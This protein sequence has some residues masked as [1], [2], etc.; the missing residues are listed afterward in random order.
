MTDVQRQP[1]ARSRLLPALPDPRPD[2]PARDDRAADRTARADG[3]WC[4][5]ACG[6]ASITAPSHR[7]SSRGSHHIAYH[8]P[9]QS[10]RLTTNGSLSAIADE[11]PCVID[12]SARIHPR[13]RPDDRGPATGSWRSPFLDSTRDYWDD[14]ARSLA[15]PFEWQEAVIRSAI[16][17][18]LC[19]YEDTGA[20]VAALTTSIPESADT[21]ATGITATAG[22]ATAFV[23]RALNRLGA[24][25]TMEEYI[26]YIFNLV[27][28]ATTTSQPLYG[29]GFEASWRSGSKPSLPAIAAWARC[30]RQPR[31]AAEAARRVRQR[32]AGVDAAVLRPAPAHPGDAE[33]FERLERSA[34]A[35][36]RCIDQPDAGLWEFRGR[37]RVHTYSARCAGPA[38]DRLARIAGRSACGARG[39]LARAR[40]RIRE[41]ILREHGTTHAG[42]SPSFGGDGLDA[43]RCC[44]RTSASS[45]PTTRASLATVDAIGRDLRRATVCSATSRRT[46]SA[47]RKPASPSARSG[48]S[49]RWP[50][51]RRDEAR[52]LFERC[53]HVATRSAC[54]R[55]TSTRHGE[56]WGNF[57]QT[58]SHVG[59]IIAPCA[60]GGL[61]GRAM[62]RARRRLEPGR[63]A[64]A[65]RAPGALPSRACSAEARGGMWFGWS[66]EVVRRR[67]GPGCRST[68]RQDSPTSRSTCRRPTSTRYYNGFANRTLWPL[69]HFRVDA[70]RLH[71]ATYAAL[72]AGQRA[73]RRAAGRR[74]CADDDL[75]WVHD[76]HLIPL[77]AASCASTA[78]AAH[79]FLPARAV[80]AVECWRRCRGTRDCCSD[81]RL[82]PGRLPDRGDLERFRD[83]RAA[84]R[85]GGSVVDDTVVRHGRRPHARRRASR[86]ASTSTGSG[87]EAHATRR[88]R[89]PC[90]AWRRPARRGSSSASTGSTTPRACR[91]LPGVR[92]LPRALSGA[93]E[94]RHLPADRAAAA[95]MCASTARSA[96]SSTGRRPHQRPLRGARLDAVALC[97][98]HFSARVADGLLS[99]RQIG[100]VTPLR[101]GMNLVAKEFVAAQD[102]DDPGVLVLSRSP[103]PRANW[104]SA[105]SWIR[106]IPTPSPMPCTWRSRCHG[107]SDA[108]VTHR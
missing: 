96:A 42:I 18:K 71:R 12:A 93:T 36:S 76:Y 29:I 107:T 91:T 94:R 63:P 72:P 98:S 68:R 43:S 17:L 19:Q 40:R 99:R 69:L 66:G 64:A 52:E 97:Q 38:C 56:L 75:V 37:A 54:C 47:R 60:C 78:C 103:A 89:R 20:I 105:C 86:S 48:T 14:W 87:S 15:I 39:L 30:A 44:W 104:P 79:R 10:F 1:A 8:G 81:C 45:P 24:T 74:C 2:L 25:R 28:A 49:T 108:R 59:L 73:V 21:V 70:V 77:G 84:V 106:S 35:P 3:P 5:C 101:D 80:P 83:S 7:G 102:P 33:L 100:L 85:A 51:G 11:S 88:H 61:G 82:R 57:P 31:L 67:A 58:Y 6:P 55:R 95:R 9:S 4:G 34:S 62:S 92:A 53:W 13:A 32:G 41:R 26:R 46:T 50:S 65:R 22:C 90:S 16:T 23:V 27:A